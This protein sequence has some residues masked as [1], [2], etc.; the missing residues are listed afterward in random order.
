MAWSDLVDTKP[1]PL[2]SLQANRLCKHLELAARFLQCVVQV[3]LGHFIRSGRKAR[4]ILLTV[5]ECTD[6]LGRLSHNLQEV[7]G[8]SLP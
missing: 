1:T 6:T 4:E 2:T 8:C 7:G 5:A 3:S